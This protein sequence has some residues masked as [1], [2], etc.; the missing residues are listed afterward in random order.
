MVV[1]HCIIIR[2]NNCY[3]LCITATSLSKKQECF[4]DFMLLSL[5]DKIEFSE[6]VDNSNQL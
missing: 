6:V 5:C 1:I 4:E 2:Q 3:H